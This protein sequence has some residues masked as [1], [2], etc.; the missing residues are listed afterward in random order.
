MLKKC[1]M[2][3]LIADI[4]FANLVITDIVNLK[5]NDK[6]SIY[7]LRVEFLL[8]DENCFVNLKKEKGLYSTDNYTCL[9]KD[10]TSYNSQDINVQKKRYMFYLKLK[11]EKTDELSINFE[12]TIKLEEYTLFKKTFYVKKNP[13][14]MKELYGRIKEMYARERAEKNNISTN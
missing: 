4:M 9:K 6:L 7:D 3:I 8:K 1:L 11:G 12:K 14:K 2:I 5:E 13:V 10:N